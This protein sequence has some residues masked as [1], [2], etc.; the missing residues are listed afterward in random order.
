MKFEHGKVS[1]FGGIN[2]LSGSYA[3][4]NDTVTMG[5]LVS[6]KMAGDPALMELEAN[7]AKALASVDAFEVS[8][9][10]LTL[11]SDGAVVAT[12]RSGQ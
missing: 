7:L 12:W 5:S 10:E 4:V 2:R 11:S 8:G 6:T 1:V 9:D 3:L